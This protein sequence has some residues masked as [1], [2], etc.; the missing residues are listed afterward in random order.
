VNS[1]NSLNKLR[2]TFVSGP[3][4]AN[5]SGRIF[6]STAGKGRYIVMSAWLYRTVAALRY[7]MYFRF[8]RMTPCLHIMAGNQTTDNT[9]K[10]YRP[11]HSDSTGA[12]PI[13]HHGVYS[14]A[15]RARG[16]SQ[17]STDALSEVVF[18]LSY[19]CVSHTLMCLTPARVSR[20]PHYRV[21]NKAT[22]AYIESVL[23]VAS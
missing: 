11:N 8:L 2:P 9:K 3:N 21:Y 19:C 12:A 20:R 17:I 22:M 15:A 16:R 23:P 7:V 14:W 10:T 1:V 4:D 5:I 13:W 6:R 18:N